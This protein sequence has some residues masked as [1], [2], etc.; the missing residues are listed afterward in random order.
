MATVTASKSTSKNA[1]HSTARVAMAIRTQPNSR[2]TNKLPQQSNFRTAPPTMNSVKP[3][4]SVASS[5]TGV[6][7]LM[8]ACQCDNYDKV[9]EILSGDGA[10][11]IVTACDSQGRNALHYAA[12]SGSIRCCEMILAANDTLLSSADRDG[13][14]PLHGAVIAGNLQTVRWLIEK[15]ASADVH[16]NELH[17]VL[18]WATVSAHPDLV[19]YLLRQVKVLPKPDF[20]HAYPL[21]YSA[22]MCGTSE[23]ASSKTSGPK[24]AKVSGSLGLTSH[25]ARLTLLKLIECGH[26][27]I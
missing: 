22:Q 19:E 23:R 14:Y 8:A 12:E 15:G 1:L 6:T 18:H 26:P 20:H 16:D 3:S 11:K 25:M 24:S 13:C 17:S 2:V 9:A 21:H 27:V 4:G 7:M 10:S 5:V